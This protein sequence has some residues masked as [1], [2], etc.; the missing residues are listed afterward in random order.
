MKLVR[1]LP[2]LLV[3]LTGACS[4][5]QEGLFDPDFEVYAVLPA[6]GL[7]DR[8]FVDVVYE[9]I[10]VAKKDFNFS[11]RYV[12]PDSLA[13]GEDWIAHIP[14]LKGTVAPQILVIIAGNQY[15]GAVD[16]LKGSFG[17]SKI[18]LLPGA[19][20]EHDGLASVSYRTYA[21]SY[22]GGYLSAGLIP[23]CRALVV[24]AFDAPFLRE[25]RDGFEQGVTDAGGIVNSP[26]YIATGYEGFSMSDSAYSLT[27]SLLPENDLIYALGSGSNFGIINAAR[28]YDEPRFVMGV[29]ADQSWMGFTVVTG[30]V[31]ILYDLEIY[32]YISE[33][34]N[35]SFSS[36]HFTRTMAEGKISFLI[37]RFVLGEITVSE[38]LINTAIEKEKAYIPPGK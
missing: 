13:A 4:S 18:L 30:S 15:C 33:F 14:E 38:T 1:T 36:G 22:L 9:G 17:N 16:R 3:M 28:D 27:R 10:E 21:P 25:F 6:E 24:E 34:S 26:V 20:R 35:G 5:E 29:D 2:L 12:I 19:A 7:G 32:E 11:V 31:V 37:N 23:G 8:S